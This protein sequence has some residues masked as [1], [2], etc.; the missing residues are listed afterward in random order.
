MSLD[1]YGHVF[2]E[3]EGADRLS[4]EEQIRRARAKY[5]SILCPFPELADSGA[6]EN[7]KKSPQMR[8][9]PESDSNRRPLPYHRRVSTGFD[10]QS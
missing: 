3:L 1:T 7:H 8:K 10:T 2:D 6:G 5:V 9:S 4:A